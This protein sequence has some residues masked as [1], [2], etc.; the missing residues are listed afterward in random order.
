M[1][2]R[3]LT[4][5]NFMPYKGQTQIDFPTEEFR[6][7]MLVFGDNMRGKTSFLNALRWGFYQEVIGRHSI[8]I[9]FQEVPNKEA[10]SEGDWTVEVFI[11]FEADGHNYDLRRRAEK[12]PHILKPQRPEDFVTQ[13][14]L[15]KDGM[16]VQGDLVE[17][18]IN[19]IAP[20]QRPFR[21]GLSG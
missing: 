18:E 16:P 7:V 12:R 8:P 11:D 5:R 3:Q 20:H 10:A 4:I 14:F 19:H 21:K 1:K 17:A 15:K 2:L 13:V 9:P 6:N